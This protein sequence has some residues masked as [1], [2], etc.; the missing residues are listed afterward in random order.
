MT[1]TGYEMAAWAMAAVLLASTGQ[2]E[3]RA[4]ITISPK[5]NDPVPDD[6]LLTI[7]V[8]PVLTTSTAPV[9]DGKLDDE[10]WQAAPRLGRMYLDTGDGPMKFDTIAKF[11][12]DETYIYLAV[13]ARH[14]KIADVPISAGKRDQVSWHGETVELFLDTDP[15][16]AGYVQV[17]FDMSG[18][19]T[20]T[21]AG[22]ESFNGDI[23]A[24]LDP[25]PLLRTRT[26]QLALSMRPCRRRHSRRRLHGK[27]TTSSSTWRFPASRHSRA[28]SNSRVC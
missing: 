16:G 13:D 10:A 26:G 28:P 27:A 19:F 4:V 9:I 8:C 2:A 21:F 7:P 1:R 22:H 20:D 23:V 15:A 24:D 18:A 12:R 25:R 17:I 3:N 14:P 5:V 6:I 11:T